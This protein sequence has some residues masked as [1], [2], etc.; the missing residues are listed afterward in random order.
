M[1][2][3]VPAAGSE[4]EGQKGTCR[5]VD[6]TL[7]ALPRRSGKVLRKR[8]ERTK[9]G[10]QSTACKRMAFQQALSDVRC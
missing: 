6:H 2:G 3:P 5:Q 7:A 4:E 1:W 8:V 10:T 9:L